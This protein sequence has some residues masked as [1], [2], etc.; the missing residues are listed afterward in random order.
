MTVEHFGIKKENQTGPISEEECNLSNS[1]KRDSI[2][3]I[4]VGGQE[5]ATFKDSSESIPDD[6]KNMDLEDNSKD[7]LDSNSI[8][9]LIPD[10]GYGWVVV[11][12]SFMCNFTVDGICYT[13]G[14]F[15]PYFLQEFGS[16][17]GL[18]ALAGSL[19]SGCYMTVGKGLCC[20]PGSQTI[21]D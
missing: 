12:A 1:L 20:V 13:F 7:V 3:I 19:L 9:S 6:G 4:D 2:Y 17:R 15:L 16:N 18:V 21:I 8:D 14:L 5:N 10:G 11:F